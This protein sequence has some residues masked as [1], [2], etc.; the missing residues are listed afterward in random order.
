VP[1]PRQL[2]LKRGKITLAIPD[3]ARKTATLKMPD[4]SKATFVCLGAA[5][6]G[7]SRPVVR[8]VIDWRNREIPTKEEL[9]MLRLFAKTLKRLGWSLE[10][11]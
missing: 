9:R 6:I 2:A 5:N 1:K 11:R 4:G 8:K 7:G 10:T 3:P